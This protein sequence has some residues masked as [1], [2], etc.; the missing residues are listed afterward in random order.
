MKKGKRP[1][2][3]Q[4]QLIHMAGLNAENWLVVKSLPT[5]LHLVHR[6]TTTTKIIVI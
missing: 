6:Y 2:R 3:R 1:T 5:H 4:K